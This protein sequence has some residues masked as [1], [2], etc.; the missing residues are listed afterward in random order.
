[1]LLSK[2]NSYNEGCIFSFILQVVNIDAIQV[3]LTKKISLIA[4]VCMFLLL[5]LTDF[6]IIIP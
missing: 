6:K 5:C 4:F 2:Q 1:M 3:Y